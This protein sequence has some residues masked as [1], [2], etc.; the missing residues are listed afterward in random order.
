MY[1]QINGDLMTGADKE[2]AFEGRS[3]TL[4]RTHLEREIL[5]N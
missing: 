5:Q 1:Q 4:Y 3:G 2:R